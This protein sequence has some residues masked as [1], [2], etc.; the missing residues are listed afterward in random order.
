[1]AAEVDDRDQ[2]LIAAAQRGDKPAL[3]D[4]VRRNERWLRGVIFA[5][6]GHAGHVD[7]VLQTVWSQ[8]VQQLCTLADPQRWRGW[9]YRLTRNAAIDFGQAARRRERK[10][11]PIADELDTVSP[12]P[13]PDVEIASDEVHG[14]VIRAIQAL[15]AIY[16]E[17]FVLRHLENWN[18]AQIGEALN[19][20]IDTV[21]T[22]LVRARRLL[23]ESLRSLGPG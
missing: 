18:Y 16:R 5:T 1:M 23:R 12:A 20:P 10:T 19:L 8:V 14:R 9:L 15:P 13:P 3:E 11:Q 7:D 17:P 22:R 2:A 21:E 6:L 4:F